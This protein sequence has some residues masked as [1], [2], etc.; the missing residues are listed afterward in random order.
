MQQKVSVSERRGVKITLAQLQ[1]AP[2]PCILHWNQSHFVVLY[3]IVGV[4]N[5]S[6]LHR[7]RSRFYISDPAG[8]KYTLT[9]EEFLKCW[10]STVKD[11]KEAGTITIAFL[12]QQKCVTLYRPY[13]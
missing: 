7:N 11:G 5:F 10:A 12:Q 6:P 9:A 8:E 3:R 13:I 2:L 4:K 1:E